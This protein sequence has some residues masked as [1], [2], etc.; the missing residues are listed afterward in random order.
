MVGANT[1]KRAPLRNPTTAVKRTSMV[2]TRLALPTY[3]SPLILATSAA[4]PLPTIKP[5]AASSMMAGHIRL[6]AA[7]PVLPVKRDT[8]KPSTML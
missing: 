5:N 7:R 4:P 6:M 2:N 3:P 8:K 1:P